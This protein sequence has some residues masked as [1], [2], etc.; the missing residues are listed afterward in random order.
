MKDI[1]R[2]EITTIRFRKMDEQ[3]ISVVTERPYLLNIRTGVIRVSVKLHLGEL[4]SSGYQQL[5][6]TTYRDNFL[7]KPA[8]NILR[9]SMVA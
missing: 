5:L 7:S 2:G 8:F 3:C 9:L 1:S 4:A 6:E